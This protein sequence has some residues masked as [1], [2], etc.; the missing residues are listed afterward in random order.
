[1]W[2]RLSGIKNYSFCSW[3]CTFPGVYLKIDSHK[4]IDKSRSWI[5][6][7]SDFFISSW[8]FL[9]KN[10][11]GKID[12]GVLS[13]SESACLKM[14]DN[15]KKSLAG[16]T[17]H[18]NWIHDFSTSK[19]Q[20]NYFCLRPNRPNKLP[21]FH[22]KMPRLCLGV[23]KISKNWTLWLL[24]ILCKLVSYILYQNTFNDEEP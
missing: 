4:L 11:Y 5:Q 19:Y 8:L 6:S 22:I 2:R 14:W 24:R 17:T 20:Q 18:K 13:E 9:I 15:T 23:L 21:C 3:I 12:R 16:S 10:A 7:G 1:M